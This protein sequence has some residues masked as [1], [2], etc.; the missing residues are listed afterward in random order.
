M[1]GWNWDEILVVGLIA[2]CV[3]GPICVVLMTQNLMGADEEFEAE[4]FRSEEHTS[5]LQSH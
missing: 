5:E 2:A 1:F 4:H 3:L